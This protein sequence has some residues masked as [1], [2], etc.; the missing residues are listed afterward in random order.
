MAVRE[1]GP[2]E[3]MLARGVEGEAAAVL[4]SAASR[5]PGIMTAEARLAQNEANIVGRAAEGNAGTS[6]LT[7]AVEKPLPGQSQW[8]S[9][10]FEG[11]IAGARGH[12][13]DILIAEFERYGAGD[14]QGIW[15][16]KSGS[17]RFDPVD[18]AIYFS[19][20]ASTWNRVVGEEVQHALDYAQGARDLTE[21]ARRSYAA[22]ATEAN[23]YEWWH[24]RVFT[25]LIQNADA[26]RY[27]LRYLEPHLEELHQVYQQAFGGRLSLEQIL[28]TSFKGLY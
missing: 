19:R 18:R 3:R 7:H 26:E 27:G 21:I 6:R 5:E 11:G 28:S 25:R 10:Q 13:D 23:I 9:S 15:K 14:F 20:E 22:G 4:R 12:F 8:L 17:T 1:A 16:A 24:R 2:A